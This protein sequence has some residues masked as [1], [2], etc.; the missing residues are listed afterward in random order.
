MG[1]GLDAPPASPDSAV[2]VGVDAIA[3]H[4]SDLFTK[5]LDG[6]HPQ[7]DLPERFG[8]EGADR[9]GTA[10]AR[11]QGGGREPSPLGRRSW[12]LQPPFFRQIRVKD[13]HVCQF[14]PG[15]RDA[16]GPIHKPVC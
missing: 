13:L 11:G 12:A 10:G 16:R 9:V 14:T 5:P 8:S 4:S 2:G 15:L 7:G 1:A 3:L 6:N